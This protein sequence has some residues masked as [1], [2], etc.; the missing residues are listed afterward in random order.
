MTDTAL[1]LSSDSV[2]LS[3]LHRKAVML[4]TSRKDSLQTTDIEKLNAAT[5]GAPQK[6]LVAKF[7][8]QRPRTMEFI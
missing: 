4:S 5:D 7:A 8:K 6:T 2:L 1:L 3:L